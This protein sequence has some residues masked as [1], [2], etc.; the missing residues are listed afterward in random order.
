MRHRKSIKS[1]SGYFK[2]SIILINIIKLTKIKR[3]KTQITNVSIETEDRTTYMAI[4][5]R[6]IR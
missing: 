4:I 1:K 3:K 5:I 6:I 2:T